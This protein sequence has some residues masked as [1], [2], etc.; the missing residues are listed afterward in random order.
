MI[1]MHNKDGRCLIWTE[2]PPPRPT[3]LSVSLSLSPVLCSGLRWRWSICVSVCLLSSGLSDSESINTSA[4]L[5]L[6]FFSFNLLSAKS[7]QRPSNPAQ[8]AAMHSEIAPCYLLKRSLLSMSRF[9]CE[10]SSPASAALAH[11][12]MPPLISF[13]PP[14]PLTIMYPSR[15]IEPA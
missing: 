12:S 13:A 4:L 14:S 7:R 15:R 8:P 3:L 11:R 6:L 10:S 9:F 2:K 5:L 1:H